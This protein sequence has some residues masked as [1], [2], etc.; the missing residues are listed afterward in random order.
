MT[1][2]QYYGKITKLSQMSETF[3]QLEQFGN[4]SKNFLKKT[5]EKCLTLKKTC[6]KLMK[7]LAVSELNNEP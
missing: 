6:A 4:N 2:C 5:L 1:I 3:K 7:S